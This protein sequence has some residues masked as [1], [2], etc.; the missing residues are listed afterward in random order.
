MNEKEFI[1]S[2]VDGL[3]KGFGTETG[4]LFGIPAHLRDSVHMIVKLAVERTIN[5]LQGGDIDGSND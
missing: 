1:T 2:A 5:Q 3:Y 4:I